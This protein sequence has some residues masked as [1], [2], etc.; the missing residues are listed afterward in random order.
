VADESRA[1]VAGEQKAVADLQ[2]QRDRAQHQLNRTNAQLG[3]ATDLL[4]LK[5]ETA[6]EQ[7]KLSAA[8]SELERV[9]TAIAGKEKKLAEAERKLTAATESL[10]LTEAVEARHAAAI[11]THKAL[12][13]SL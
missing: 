3:K 13:A 7:K 12:V 6:E 5:Y 9:T 11:N 10:A 2:T 1:Q 8:K 4:S